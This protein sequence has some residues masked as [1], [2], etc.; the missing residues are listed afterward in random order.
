MLPLHSLNWIGEMLKPGI[1]F[2]CCIVMLN[3]VCIY[4]GFYIAVEDWMLVG[5]LPGGKTKK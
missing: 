2:C 1:Y 3:L 4:I 5:S